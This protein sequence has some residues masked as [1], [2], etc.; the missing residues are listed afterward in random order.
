MKAILG[1]GLFLAAVAPWWRVG[2][3][4]HGETLEMR[5][6]SVLALLQIFCTRAP[7]SIQN[8]YTMLDARPSSST[9]MS[10]RSILLPHFHT[11]AFSL[12]TCLTST[13]HKALDDTTVAQLNCSLFAT[14][15]IGLLK[16]FGSLNIT[17]SL[18]V[19]FGAVLLFDPAGAPDL[20]SWE[21]Q[22]PPSCPSTAKTLVHYSSALFRNHPRSHLWFIVHLVPT[23]MKVLD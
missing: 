15:M 14:K 9:S 23:C 19:Q 10:M 8:P 17:T 5:A 13:N 21:R 7:E 1:L 22:K 11:A 2:W 16:F 6:L 3:R 18:I 20:K 4:V 12:L